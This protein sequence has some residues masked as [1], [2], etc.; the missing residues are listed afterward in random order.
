MKIKTGDKINI[1]DNKSIDCISG[2]VAHMDRNNRIY[3]SFNSQLV[4]F[5]TINYFSN[6]SN[7]YLDY[8]NGNISIPFYLLKRYYKSTSSNISL[9]IK[10]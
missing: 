9:K 6:L 8:A 10:E 2:K 3:I 7:V 1:Y 5:D 4:S